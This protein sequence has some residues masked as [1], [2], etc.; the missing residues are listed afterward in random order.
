MDSFTGRRGRRC[1]LQT[2]YLKRV[3]GYEG[4]VFHLPSSL[5]Q[6]ILRLVMRFKERDS[7]SSL[8]WNPP[9]KERILT[10]G[11]PG[12]FREREREKERERERYMN[13]EFYMYMY[14]HKRCT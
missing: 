1:I 6:V 12:G 5:K 8:P 13:G 7:P 4:H 14:I 11:Q 10:F 9:M 3:L 2:L